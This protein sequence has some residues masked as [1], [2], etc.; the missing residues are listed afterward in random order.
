[1]AGLPMEFTVTAPWKPLDCRLRCLG[2]ISRAGIG[3]RSWGS[4]R[5]ERDGWLPSRGQM[6]VDVLEDRAAC[7]S[8]AA[9]FGV[10]SPPGSSLLEPTR[11]LVCAPGEV[12]PFY[13]STC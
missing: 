12:L 5:W 2:E 8:A 1:M 3:F 4:V 13:S 11:P 7:C 9:G 6:W 10:P